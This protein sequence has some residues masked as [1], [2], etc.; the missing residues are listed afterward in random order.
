[1]IM[2]F[3]RGLPLLALLLLPCNLQGG[4][5]PVSLYRRYLEAAQKAIESESKGDRLAALENYRR[6]LEWLE[7]ISSSHSDWFP[8]IVTSRM[9]ESSGNIERIGSEIEGGG[10][11]G[12]EGFSPDLAVEAMGGNEAERGGVY[13]GLVEDICGRADGLYREG[14]YEE[15][16]SEYE[17]V[18][19]LD[20]DHARANFQLGLIHS[21]HIKDEAKMERYWGRYRAVSLS[22]MGDLYSRD[23]RLLTAI[24]QYREALEEDPANPA[25]RRRLADVYFKQLRYPE[26]M[27]EYRLILSSDGG[28]LYSRFQL[29]AIHA[30]VESP[31]RAIAELDFIRKR[32]SDYPGLDELY[33]KC[34]K[35]AG[36]RES[37]ISFYEKVVRG[38]PEGI[39]PYL[40]LAALYEEQEKSRE[41]AVEILALGLARFPKSGRLAREMGRCCVELGDCSRARGIYEGLLEQSPDDADSVIGLGIISLA[42]GDA[43]AA[44]KRFKEALEMDPSAANALFCLASCRDSMG[45]GKAAEAYLEKAVALEIERPDAYGKLAGIYEENS[46]TKKAADV[47]NRAVARWPGRIDMRK[48]LIALYIS[49]GQDDAAIGELERYVEREES[50]ATAFVYL[51]NL[52]R[53]K[54]RDAEAVDAYRRARGLDPRIGGLARKIGILLQR[55]GEYSAALETYLIAAKE[56]P[57]SAMLHNNIAVCYAHK[58]GFLESIAEYEKALELDPDLA[59]A[60]IDMAKL[61]GEKLGKPEKAIEHCCAYLE[62]RPDGEHAPLVKEMLMAQ[63]EARGKR[64]K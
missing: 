11:P 35:M 32:S 51:G 63:K 31:E 61:Y 44:E 5:L 27:E 53:K 17:M 25:V 1:M 50:D 12:G 60:H 55:Q 64:R 19:K 43:A 39:D 59:E 24:E 3:A 20:P 37:A 38:E 2:D 52:L 18:L 26:A 21:E 15:A 57:G 62:I 14:R 34:K 54:E 46:E 13:S 58:G 23:G 4:E 42:E 28:D 8:D 9:A 36:E 33:A 56:E 6:A 30:E 47:L 41:K 49:T 48:R 7:R 45:D 16:C 29:A 22:D 10:V 40:E